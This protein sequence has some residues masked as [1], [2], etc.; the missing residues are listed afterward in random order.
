MRTFISACLLTALCSTSSIAQTLDPATAGAPP[1]PSTPPAEQTPQPAQESWF[2][3]FAIVVANANFNAKTLVPGSVAYFA[4]PDAELNTGQ[5]NVSGGNTFFGVDL[6][7]PKVGNYQVNAKI[8]LNLRGSTP[9]TNQNVFE[10]L[11]GD[12]YLEF[13][14]EDFRFLMGQ[15][16]DVISPLAPTTLNFYPLSY[17]PGSLG[18]F[19]PMIRAETYLPMGGDAQLTVQAAL[20]SAI[21]TFRINN[22]AFARQSGWPDGQLR[23]A[24]GVGHPDVQGSRPTEFGVS[25]HFGR[26]DLTYTDLTEHFRNT[27]SINFDGKAQIGPNTKVQGELFFGQLLGDYMG[28]VFQSFNPNTGNSVAA[29]GGWAEVEQ[30]FG[31]GY[32]VHIGYGVDNVDETDVTALTSRKQN[33]ALYAN[34][35]YDVTPALS[36]AG[37]LALWRTQYFNDLT[38]T[39]TRLEFSVI[40]K[41][42]GR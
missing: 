20:A 3:P 40:Y 7:G 21:Q 27:Y 15:T 8:D 42:F 25:S 26:R 4:A 6:K 17:A 12:V 18:F 35:F 39:P 24:Y 16:V 23:V 31:E 32:R 5:F 33:G 34:L 10:P 36:V 9:I 13:K 28:A 29:K 2:Q 19:R 1:A 22:E 41:F 14:S 37:E 38:A 11:F 30:K